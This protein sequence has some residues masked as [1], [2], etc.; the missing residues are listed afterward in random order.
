MGM[1][2]NLKAKIFE[3]KR[4]ENTTHTTTYIHTLFMNLLRYFKNGKRMS[5]MPE[6][7]K[8]NHKKI[9][10]LYVS[11]PYYVKYNY[12]EIICVHLYKKLL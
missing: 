3:K 7:N 2:L 6:T 8:K 12:Y 1:F 4:Y 11:S 10:F 9:Q 5:I